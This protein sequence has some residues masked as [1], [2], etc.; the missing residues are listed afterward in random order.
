MTAH[1]IDNIASWFPESLSEDQILEINEKAI[2]INT[3][4]VTKFDLGFFVFKHSTSHFHKRSRNCNADTK[5]LSTSQFV[6]I[7]QNT[8]KKCKDCNFLLH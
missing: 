2:S 7:F 4:K 1:E 6:Y 8:A 3:K 5:K